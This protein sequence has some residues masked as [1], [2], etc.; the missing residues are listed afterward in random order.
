MLLF[1]RNLRKPSPFSARLRVVGVGAILVASL[2]APC[3]AGPALVEKMTMQGSDRGLILAIEADREFDLSVLPQSEKSAVGLTMK[4]VIYGLPE[5]S[6]ATFPTGCPA[7]RLQIKSGG[8]HTPLELVARFDGAIQLTPSARKKGNVWLVL[9]STQRFPNFT[10]TAPTTAAKAVQETPSETAKAEVQPD[11]PAKAVAKSTGSPAIEKVSVQKPAASPVVSAKT[12]PVPPVK[13]AA[14]K[15]PNGNAEVPSSHSKVESPKAL[16]RL[17]DVKVLRRG[18]IEEVIFVFDMPVRAAVKRQDSDVLLAFVNAASNLNDTN[19]RNV[20]GSFFGAI[21]SE[22]AKHPSG[23]LLKITFSNTKSDR[24]LI[25]EPRGTQVVVGAL[26]DSNPGLF[27]WS[28]ALG[29]QVDYQFARLD[30][31]KNLSELK[32]KVAAASEREFEKEKT[33]TLKKPASSTTPGA[34]GARAE[35]PTEKK[36]VSDD[37]QDKVAEPSAKTRQEAPAATAMV[38]N[39]EVE[40]KKETTQEKSDAPGQQRTSVAVAEQLKSAVSEAPTERLVVI[41][42]A[43][44]FRSKPVTSG[45]ETII[46]QLSLGAMLTQLEKK[47]TWYRVRTGQGVEGWIYGSLVK[48]SSDVNQ[49]VWDEIARKKAPEPPAKPD[50]VASLEKNA[51]VASPDERVEE[52]PAAPA[53]AAGDKT[54]SPE[55]PAPPPKPQPIRYKRSGRDPF[56]RLTGK[57]S[58]EEYPDVE[59]VRLVGILFDQDDRVALLENKAEKG[60]AYALR[61]GDRV[62]NGK[63]LRIE[64]ERVYFLVTEFDLSRTVILRLEKDKTKATDLIARGRQNAADRQETMGEGPGTPSGRRSP[65][66][67]SPSWT[68][69]LPP[70]E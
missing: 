10:W 4:N 23:D 9:L 53:P 47:G 39:T 6:Y 66:P 42:D 5:L 2:V 60:K 7:R 40:K 26:S 38:S 27:V 63:L 41:K 31:N 37:I 36:E 30:E 21:R 24:K 29:K 70:L 25:I 12:A 67:G 22:S 1:W 17:Q 34:S 62:K 19:L 50:V 15:G 28:A 64:R 68:S 49:D 59:L 35:T 8:K 55:R 58:D 61:E 20:T 18:E 11:V 43:V 69:D 32:N 51:P 56:I 33:F 45:N 3:F 54:V 52:R 48:D 57:T 13:R 44:N 46:S 16:A 14:E 65:S